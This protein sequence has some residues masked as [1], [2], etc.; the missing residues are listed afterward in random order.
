MINQRKT[1]ETMKQ[2]GEK[3]CNIHKEMRDYIHDTRTE[4]MD[5]NKKEH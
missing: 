4:Q 2:G 5:C 1:L 3:N